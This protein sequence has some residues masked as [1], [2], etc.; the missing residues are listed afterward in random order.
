MKWPH[1]REGENEVE[2]R[3]TFIQVDI[4]TDREDGLAFID[5]EKHSV[6]GGL[7]T[8]GTGV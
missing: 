7:L 2:K 4:L 3:D 1:Y 5:V 6:H 8:V